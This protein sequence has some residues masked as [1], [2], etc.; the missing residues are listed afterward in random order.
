MKHKRI[1]FVIILLVILLFLTGNFRTYMIVGASDL[2]TFMPGDKVIINR[3]AYD[4]T[5]PFSSVKLLPLGKPQRGDMVLCHFSKSDMNEYWLKRIIG[6]PGDTVEI[7]QHRITINHQP[8]RYEILKHDGF[9]IPKGAEIGDILANEKGLGL[10][11]TVA[12]TATANII[13]SFGPVIVTRDHYFV[14][15]DNRINSLDSRFLGLVNRKDIFGKL[16]FRIY[17][18]E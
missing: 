4:L 6:L 7:K 18:G 14:L 2:P 1:S 11:H 12:V 9:E 10:N 3:S 8:V 17:K 13:S 15:G 16:L 5:F